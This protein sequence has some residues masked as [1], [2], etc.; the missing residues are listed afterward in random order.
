MGKWNTKLNYHPRYPPL[1][2][3]ETDGL[4]FSAIHFDEG[5]KLETPVFSQ[6]LIYLIDIVVEKLFWCGNGGICRQTDK[7]KADA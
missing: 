2:D 7:R 4:S 3:L 5:L 1:K 6:W